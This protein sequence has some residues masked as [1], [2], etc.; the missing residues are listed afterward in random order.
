M[1]GRSKGGE[2][3]DGERREKES[4]E[5]RKRGKERQERKWH[6]KGIRVEMELSGATWMGRTISYTVSNIPSP[7]ECEH[8]LHNLIMS[9]NR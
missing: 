8:V 4:R 6:V 2:K 9:S 1:R 5:N 7:T 3:R